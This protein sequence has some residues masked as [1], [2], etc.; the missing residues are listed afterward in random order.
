MANPTTRRRSRAVQPRTGTRERIM[1]AG[2]SLFA[3]RGYAA[4]SMRELADRAGV[5]LSAS[6]H[7]FPGKHDV[8]VAIMIEAMDR[9]EAAALEVLKR[10][11]PP[12]KRLPQL[13]RAH[14]LIHLQVPD[15]ARVADGELRSLDVQARRE[16]VAL[17]DR[18]ESYFREAL[19]EGVAEGSFSSGLDVPVTAMA[20]ITMATSTLVWYRPDG[21]L[22]AEEVS[23]RLSA[24]AL[25]M[26]TQGR[27]FAHSAGGGQPA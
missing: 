26:A 22:S 1:A 11:L 8:L 7:H 2:T 6:Y 3:E 10:D 17:R 9:L 18:Y 23:D 16:M 14:V 19:A 25:A 5:S 4:A 27:G 13:V 20:I 24:S 21:R 12:L 15:A